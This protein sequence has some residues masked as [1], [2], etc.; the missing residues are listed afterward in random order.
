MGKEEEGREV[1]RQTFPLRLNPSGAHFY[2]F[3]LAHSLKDAAGAMEPK[4]WPEG[5][6]SMTAGYWNDELRLVGLLQAGR[7]NC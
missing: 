1:Q 5:F 3:K 2:S 7:R 6:A 4:S